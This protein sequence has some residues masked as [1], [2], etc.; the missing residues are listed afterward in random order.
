M[1]TKKSKIQYPLAGFINNETSNF[2][3]PNLNYE[4]TSNAFGC[5][6]KP[7]TIG[8]ISTNWAQYFNMSINN[9]FFQFLTVNSQFEIQ[10][11]QANAL[12]GTTPFSIEFLLRRTGN[13]PNDAGLF[14]NWPVE[15]FF[16]CRVV[17]STNKLFIVQ[18]GI[19]P[20][21]L[22][23]ATSNSIIS[24]NT[25]YSILITNDG[26]QLKLFI[27]G[28]DDGIS[29][30]GT[31][32]PLVGN[33]PNELSLGNIGFNFASYRAINIEI[34]DFRSSN[35]IVSLPEHKAF[36]NRSITARLNNFSI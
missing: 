19:P 34:G 26:S 25:I 33:N 29:P 18:K 32:Y 15:P 11:Q 24:V 31:I 23:T 10:N 3:S 21:S 22:V 36:V 2:I 12:N 5:Y 17:S 4:I 28:V 27:N 9:G 6:T 14:G 8:G 13:L 7:Y 16:Y 30:S 1:P 35:Y 20:L